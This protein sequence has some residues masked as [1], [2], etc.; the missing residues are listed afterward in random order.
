MKRSA[1][2]FVAVI[3]LSAC[4]GASKLSEAP[5]ASSLQACFATRDAAKA[6]G[7][8][9]YATRG[10]YPKT[11]FAMTKGSVPALVAND[12]TTVTANAITGTGWTL[13][14]SGGGKTEPTFTCASAPPTS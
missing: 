13:T 4:G 12:D 11:F 14:I 3:A 5:R 1:I 8:V 9:V 10:N 6:A 2:V 7:A